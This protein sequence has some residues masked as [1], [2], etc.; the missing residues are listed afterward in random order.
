MG[1]LGCLGAL[2]LPCSSSRYS[3]LSERQLLVISEQIPKAQA[4]SIGT[5][6]MVRCCVEEER[7]FSCHNK[8]FGLEVHVSLLYVYT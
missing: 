2:V 1:I 6:T 8:L 7:F 3:S 4:S 5:C